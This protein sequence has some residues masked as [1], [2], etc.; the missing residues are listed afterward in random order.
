VL[1]KCSSFRPC[2]LEDTSTSVTETEVT[3]SKVPEN[4]WTWKSRMPFL[5]YR[6]LS[7]H[8]VD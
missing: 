5:V 4:T 8:S 6:A 2:S 1:V 3:V 7:F